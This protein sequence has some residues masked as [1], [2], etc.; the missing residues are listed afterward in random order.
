[1]RSIAEVMTY[2]YRII[3]MLTVVCGVVIIPA[4]S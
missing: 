1:M 4:R 2:A 3:D